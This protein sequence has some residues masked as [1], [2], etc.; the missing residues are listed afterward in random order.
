MHPTRVTHLG[1]QRKLMER[2]PQRDEE[3]AVLFGIA[4]GPWKLH[5]HAAQLASAMEGPQAFLEM[6]DLRRAERPFVRKPAAQLHGEQEF[7]IVLHLLDPQA[8]QF[9]PDR[10]IEA[11]VDFDRVEIGG[12]IFQGVKTSL[13]QPG[14]NNAVPV[15]IRPT[16]GTARE[17]SGEGHGTL[18]FSFSSLSSIG[19]YKAKIKRLLNPVFTY[20]YR[21]HL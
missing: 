3:G 6:R 16:G 7:R 13:L 8:R 2:P 1:H 15:W 17:C 21:A 14:I 19:E 4:K 10:L 20:V 18:Y 11:G 12:Q 5:E 9:R